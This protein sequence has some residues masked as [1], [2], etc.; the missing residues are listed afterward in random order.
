MSSIIENQMTSKAIEAGTA[1]RHAYNQAK[2]W[3]AVLW[4]ITFGLATAQLLATVCNALPTS[5]LYLTSVMLLGLYILFGSFGKDRLQQ[6][7]LR[8]CMIQRY[9]DFLTME[10]GRK[11][12]VLEM[13]QAIITKLSTARLKKHPDD[14][15]ILATWWSSNLATVQFNQARLISVFSSISWETE[16]RKQY[17]IFLISILLLSLIPP[18]GFSIYSEFTIQESIILA[19]APFTPFIGLLL[20]EILIN[21]RCHQTTAGLLNK[22]NTMWE[23]TLQEKLEDAELRSATE[24]LMSQWQTY[25]S[26]ALPI[27]EWLY[28][29]SRTQMEK[30][31]VINTDSLIEELKC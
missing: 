2:N 3:K 31:M 21:W 7:Y 8:G 29:L 13:T 10:V 1:F 4:I 22:C 14:E 18:I 6:L 20:E 30:D 26:T 16:L 19:I 23:N 11:P 9:H 15:A 12:N 5:G 25:R 24:D 27:F 28:Y 17:N